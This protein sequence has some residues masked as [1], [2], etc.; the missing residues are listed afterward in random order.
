MENMDKGLTVPKWLL[1]DWPKILP[2]VPLNLSAQAQKFKIS[3]ENGFI[4]RPYS[5]IFVIK[6]VLFDCGQRD[7][8]WYSGSFLYISVEIELIWL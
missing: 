3:M 4:G 8:A 1:I 2:Q 6:L 5:V 7:G